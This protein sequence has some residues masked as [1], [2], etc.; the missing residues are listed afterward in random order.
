MNIKKNGTNIKK[1][2]HN[3]EFWAKLA[4]FVCF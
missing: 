2:T 4:L 1:H 3:V